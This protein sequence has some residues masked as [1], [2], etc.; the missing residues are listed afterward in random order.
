MWTGN[1]GFRGQ[2]E[3]QLKE[4]SNM[5]RLRE[6][7]STHNKVMWVRGYGWGTDSICYILFF[8]AWNSITWRGWGTLIHCYR[9]NHCNLI[10]Q[11][12]ISSQGWEPVIL[13]LRGSFPV[14]TGWFWDIFK[15]RAISEMESWLSQN[16]LAKFP[17]TKQW[18]LLK[19]HESSKKY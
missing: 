8:I 1:E 10:C 19:G 7:W 4:Y 13:V 11:P 15:I 12:V 16:Y 17:N 2:R 6:V 14:D 9:R 3:P 18:K 5:E